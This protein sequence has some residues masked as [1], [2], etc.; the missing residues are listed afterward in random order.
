L[1]YFSERVGE[2]LF[3]KFVLSKD[4]LLKVGGGAKMNLH[5][6]FRQLWDAE[7]IEVYILLVTDERPNDNAEC[8]QTLSSAN[9]TELTV[10]YRS[11][12]SVRRYGRG[13]S[14]TSPLL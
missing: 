2:K 6:G 12:Y 13:N 5:G 8:T 10:F 7:N 3:K 1:C 14:E 4:A 11:F 9:E